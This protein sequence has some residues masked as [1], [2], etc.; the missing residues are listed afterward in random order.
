MHSL[1]NFLALNLKLQRTIVE[2]FN[3]HDFFGHILGGSDRSQRQAKQGTRQGHVTQL[4]STEDGDD[5]FVRC[6]VTSDEPD[7]G[8]GTGH[9]LCRASV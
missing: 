9:A 1:W 8:F 5:G 7:G 6:D 3:L 4:H 2:S